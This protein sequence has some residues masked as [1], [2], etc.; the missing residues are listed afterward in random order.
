MKMNTLFVIA[1]L[2]TAFTTQDVTGNS[3]ISLGNRDKVFPMS[4]SQTNELLEAIEQ[5]DV[6][7]VRSL[8]SG[9]M[10]MSIQFDNEETP[11]H[12]AAKMGHLNVTQ[13]LIDNKANVNNK[14][15]FGKT[16]LH[17]AAGQGDVN[18]VRMLITN[19]ADIE[20]R[21]KYNKSPLHW[22]AGEGH[23]EIVK[24]L[25]EHGAEV[26]DKTINGKTAL[27]KAAKRGHLNVSQ[28]LIENGAII[29]AKDIYERTP[30]YLAA[31]EGHVELVKFLIEHRADINSRNIYGETTLM[32]AAYRGHK[33]VTQLLIEN[34]AII[35]TKNISEKTPDYLAADRVLLYIILATMLL[36][37]I[38]LVYIVCQIHNR[39]RIGKLIGRGHLTDVYKGELLPMIPCFEK[40]TVAIK[41]I[42]SCSGSFSGTSELLAEINIVKR[43]PKH[44]NVVRFI[45]AVIK[46]PLKGEIKVIYEF[47]PYGD[48]KSFLKKNRQSSNINQKPQRAYYG[49]G[50][51]A[52]PS[53]ASFGYLQTP[54]FPYTTLDLLNWS[55]QV[56]KGLQFLASN[57]PPII[58]RD[59][60]VRN[61][62]LCEN[63]VVKI[64]DF[65][66]SRQLIGCEYYKKTSW[67]LDPIP[68]MAIESFPEEN[69]PKFSVKSDVWSFGVVLWELFSEGNDPDYVPL[70][71]LKYGLRL[72]KPKKG[73]ERNV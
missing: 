46:N 33:N 51:E 37:P 6:P 25:I 67:G 22:A 9:R 73:Y 24:F 21:D 71:N 44:S 26:N 20:A 18:I 68:W 47:C 2:V 43:L 1:M 57:D 65:G 50:E 16:P 19:K 27:H 69:E 14:D 63:K 40:K 17:W 58:H 3:T 39:L 72:R 35:N 38:Y 64:G 30:I 55:A 11:L 31:K 61:I 23:V 60:A 66:L 29:D 53:D 34:G 4:K 49:R 70:D 13:V 12:I 52:N 59:L 36:L 8:I 10:N 32:E 62:L 45:G 42:K 28:L 56:A 54:N 48:L 5:D 41:R 7:K 15:N